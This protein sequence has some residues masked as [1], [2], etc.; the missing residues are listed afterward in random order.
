MRWRMPWLKATPLVRRLRPPS[1]RAEIYSRCNRAGK[2]WTQAAS[3]LAGF[4][5]LRL[6]PAGTLHHVLIMT[7]ACSF[8]N[9]LRGTEVLRRSTPAPEWYDR[10]G[11]GVTILE[12]RHAR[13]P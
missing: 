12:F 13:C 8:A 6:W 5:L 2:G 4:Q 1:S 7:V 3:A 9:N 11:G 10:L